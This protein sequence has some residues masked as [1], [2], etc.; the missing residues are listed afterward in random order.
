MFS[1][2]FCNLIL[3]ILKFKLY[4]KKYN[5]IR[6]EIRSYMVTKG[7]SYKTVALKLSERFGENVTDQSL[8]NKLAHGSLRH[9]DAK[10]IAEVLGYKIKW[11]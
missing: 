4:A 5:F 6:N 7:Q 9:I 8:N 11:E 1:F 2:T 3:Q 10:N